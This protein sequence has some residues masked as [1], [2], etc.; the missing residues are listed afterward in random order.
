M[1]TFKKPASVKGT[2]LVILL[3]AGVALMAIAWFAHGALLER[4][5]REFV[6]DR[7]KEEVSFLEHQIRDS[8]GAF[9]GL[10]TGDYFQ[11]VFH[12]AFV[13]HSDSRTIISPESWKPLL[14]P[15]IK[16]EKEG[17]IR[18]ENSEIAGAQRTYWHIG[19]PSSQTKNRLLLSLQKTSAH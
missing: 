9:D 1:T 13:Q 7:L 12:H 19:V 17:T 18:V 10:K 8:D 14:S 11:R 16:S 2:L 15:L 5:S 4:M 6:T 3:P